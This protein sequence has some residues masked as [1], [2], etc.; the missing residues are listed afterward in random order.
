ML[1][2]PLAQLKAR[3][4]LYFIR[5]NIIDRHSPAHFQAEK[6][7]L[8]F[9]RENYPEVIVKNIH[10][11]QW[12]AAC[13]FIRREKSND[14]TGKIILIGHSWGAQVSMTIAR[15]LKNRLQINVDAVISIDPI[16]KPFHTHV[17]MVPTSIDYAINY[18]QSRDK[19]LRGHQKL[20]WFGSEAKTKPPVE[21]ILIALDSSYNAHDMI[22]YQLVSTGVIQ[23]HLDDLL[24]RPN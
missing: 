13:G 12:E 17:S 20:K 6:M 14:P 2:L 24:A 8:N 7:L 16:K 21:N 10:N 3:D 5:G 22:L 15:H 23:G 18:Y 11:H 4:I 9:M 19:M 1:L